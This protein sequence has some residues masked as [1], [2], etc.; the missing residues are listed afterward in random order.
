MSH[1]DRPSETPGGASPQP[2]R[3]SPIDRSVRRLTSGPLAWGVLRFGM[4][5]VVGM[6]LYTTFNLIDMFMI[7]RLENAK[8]ALA[9]LGICDMVAALPTII[10]NGISTGTVAIIARR[11]GEGDKEGVARATWQS[12]VLI[13]AF[14][15]FFGAVGILGSS[16]IIHQLMGAKG[17]V[18]TL[19]A[20][21][22]RVVIGGSFSIFFLL[23][24]TAILRALGRSKSAAALLVCGNV[25]NLFLNLVMVYGPGPHPPVFAWIRP[26]AVALSIPRM[27]LQGTAWATLVGRTVPVI[28]GIALV[29]RILPA[30]PSP[31]KRLFRLE[32]LRP[33]WEQLGHLLHVGWPS[34][35]QLVVRIGA[36]LVVLGL[37][38]LNYT[39]A[40]DAHVLTA[41]SIC[42]RL[43]TLVLFVGMGWG[44]A[45]SSFVGTNLGAAQRM[46][47]H[48]AGLVAAGYNGLLTIAVVWVFIRYST[49]IISFFE[50][51]S[52]VL[53]AGHQYLRFVAPSYVAIAIGIVLSQ[54]MT[55]AGATLATLILDS[56]VLGLVVMPAAIVVSNVFG[57]P[58]EGLWLTLSIG[59][60]VIACVFVAYYMTGRFLNKRL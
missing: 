1:L 27:G 4:P 26:I 10:S 14:S 20:R 18:A 11:L 9:A 17:D 43:E 39:T 59:N 41:Y 29:A 54:A 58:P 34:S 46:R 50:G 52:D 51:S 12:L 30:V 33:D 3:L 31:K 23:Q 42:L 57:A 60:G 21:Y 5:L 53:D 45:A 22:L 7:S 56:A 48:R 6:T 24:L 13:A 8:V 15:I 25:L 49:P 36:I 47:A 37:I 32:Y 16:T 38:N 40:G 44:A 19:A 55:G 35:A 28:V 2:P